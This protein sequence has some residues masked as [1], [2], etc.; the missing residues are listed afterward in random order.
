MIH[1]LYTFF[2][3]LVNV[4]LYSLLTKTFKVGQRILLLVA[5]IVT[6]VSILHLGFFDSRLL[7]PTGDYF[8]ILMFSFALIILHYGSL[9]QLGIFKKSSVYKNNESKVIPSLTVKAFDIVRLKIIYILISLYQ[10]LAV[11]IPEVR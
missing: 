9:F 8:G 7:M 10:L 5:A 4:V 2:F 6:V 11:W 3:I 1:I